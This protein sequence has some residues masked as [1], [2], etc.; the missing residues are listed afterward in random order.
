MTS[1]IVERLFDHGQDAPIR[2]ILAAD[3]EAAGGECA[4][5]GPFDMTG[6]VFLP[7]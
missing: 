1:T 3:R 4:A 6:L 5:T 7:Q 2:S